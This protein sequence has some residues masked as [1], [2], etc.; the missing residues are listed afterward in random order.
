MVHLTRNLLPWL[1]LQLGYP[2]LDRLRGRQVMRRYG[3][4]MRNERLSPRQL[5]DLQR[6]RLGALITHATQTSPY[7]RERLSAGLPRG[8][9]SADVAR[10]PILRKS[11]IQ[12][13]RDA[14][15]SEAVDRSRLVPGRSGGSTGQPTHF[16]Y[17]RVGMDYLRAST[18]R[19]AGWAGYRVGMKH[20]KV[21]GSH[22]DYTRAQQIG[23]RLRNFVLRQ[24]YIAATDLRPATIA[25]RLDRVR[26]WKPEFMWGYASALHAIAEHL[27]ERGERLPVRAVISSSD[28][29]RPDMRSVMSE[30]FECP[31]FDAY[32]TREITV[33]WECWR[34]RGFHINSDVSYIEVVDA[35]G[36]PVPA[37]HSGR[38]LVTDLH[39]YGFPFIR[40]EVG[41]LGRMA[42][43]ACDCGL[44][45]PLLASLDGRSDD[46]IVRMDGSRISPPAF[47]V[48]LSD[49]E[50]LR[51]YQVRQSANGHIR[52][53]L[54]IDGPWTSAD[55]QHL[56]H[57][58]DSILGSS[59]EYQVIMC[60]SID[61]GESGKRRSVVSDLGRSDPTGPGG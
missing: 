24:D 10:L 22:F 35:N 9:T 31:V 19:N 21:T 26:H 57:G 17:D 20:V 32:S 30:A 43:D 49:F 25:A 48:L 42:A 55:E 14:I 6:E 15:V 58:L 44:P 59:L 13:H 7:Y 18:M 36:L 8:W 51:D 23:I 60:D 50:H 61:Y 4:L 5:A 34:H 37:G 2:V 45:F 46:F 3:E 28:N 12:A 52:V 1:Y 47:T 16:F 40:Y 54:V 33:G 53:S 11:D 29:L 27:V 39:N 41:D 56:R 38:I